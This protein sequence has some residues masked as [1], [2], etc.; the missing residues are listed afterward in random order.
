MCSQRRTTALGWQLITAV[1]FLICALGVGVGFLS[2]ATTVA[3]AQVTPTV[4][5]NQ[6]DY[7]PGSVVQISGAGFTPGET[8]TLQV[9]HTDGTPNGGAGHDPWDVVADYL[10]AF[11]SAWYVSPDDSSGSV[12]LLTAVGDQSGPPGAETAFFEIGRAHV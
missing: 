12:F 2:V 11:T 10:G 7:P 9:S 5:T 8:V 3:N 6:L 1:A 4:E